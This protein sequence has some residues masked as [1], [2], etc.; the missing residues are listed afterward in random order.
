MS[1]PR[2][3]AKWSA[4]AAMFAAFAVAII[5]CLRVGLTAAEGLDEGTRTLRNVTVA[6]IEKADANDL[7]AIVTTIAIAAGIAIAWYKLDIFREFEPY[8]TITQTVL[9]R[10][11]S[12]SYAL[13]IV[14]ATLTNSSKVQVKPRQGYCRLAQTSP[15]NDGEVV[16]LYQEAL[17]RDNTTELEQVDWPELYEI[18]QNWQSG[19][20]SI[21]PGEQYQE[22]Y[23]FIIARSTESVVALTVIYNP[24]YGRGNRN[25]AES[26]RCYTFHDLLRA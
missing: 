12:A 15:L 26:W 25:R 20:I 4:I 1:W 11:I 18:R 22:T 9:S 3:I 8:L 23:Q 10:T 5:L 14:T 7:R 17:A 21:E 16:A 24:L 19:D 2:I 6:A 13:V